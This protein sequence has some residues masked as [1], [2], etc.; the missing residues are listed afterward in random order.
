MARMTKKLVMAIFKKTNDCFKEA[1]T[2]EYPDVFESLDPKEADEGYMKMELV[3][4]G[5][6]W[7]TESVTFRYLSKLKGLSSEDISLIIEAHNKRKGI[8]SPVTIHALTDELFER[9]VNS[10]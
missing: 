9:S 1:L 8:R 10:T 3:R 2:E 6:S 5:L 7:R 4:R